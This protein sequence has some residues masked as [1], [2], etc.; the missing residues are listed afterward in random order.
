MDL[1]DFSFL[2]QLKEIEIRYVDLTS[3]ERLRLLI[4]KT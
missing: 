1:V 4:L 2:V 3:L